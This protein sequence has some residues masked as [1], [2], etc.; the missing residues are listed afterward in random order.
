VIILSFAKDDPIEIV[1]NETAAA[2]ASTDIEDSDPIL[3]TDFT[4]LHV[5]CALTYNVAATLGAVVKLYASKDDGTNYEN[6][7]CWQFYMPHTT[8]NT[9]ISYSAQCPHS[10]KRMKAVVTNLDLA[11]SITAI[12]VSY[13]PQTA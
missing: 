2:N 1:T 10:A 9:V 4:D 13:T 5:H 7:P 12:Y 3:T 11:Q 6:R 8:G